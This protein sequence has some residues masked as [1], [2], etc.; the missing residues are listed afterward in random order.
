VEIEY[1]SKFDALAIA[2][3]LVSAAPNACMV[4]LRFLQPFPDK[5]R[6]AIIRSIRIIKAR[7][8]DQDDA[9]V[10]E[11]DPDSANTLCGCSQIGF[12]PFC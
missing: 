2:N 8:I 12:R 9:C 3:Y 5:F 10:V 1:A 7:G 11:P 6:N 4:A